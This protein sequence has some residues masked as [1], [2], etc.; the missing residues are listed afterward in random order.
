MSIHL[1]H[2]AVGKASEEALGEAGINGLWT[3]GEYLCIL[4]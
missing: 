3:L 1:I 4:R 2:G